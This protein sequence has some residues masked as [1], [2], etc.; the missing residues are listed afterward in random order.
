MANLGQS[1][2]ESARRYVDRVTELLDCLTAMQ[3]DSEVF[4]AGMTTYLL[5]CLTNGAS[6]DFR[7]RLKYE[8]PTTMAQA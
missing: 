4:R 2:G 1:E 6:D 3:P 7:L 5:S 8:E